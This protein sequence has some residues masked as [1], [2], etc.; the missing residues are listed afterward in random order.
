MNNLQDGERF[1]VVENIHINKEIYHP[2]SRYDDVEDGQYPKIGAKGT[3]KSTYSGLRGNEEGYNQEYIVKWDIQN[4]TR[5]DLVRDWMIKRISPRVGDMAQQISH[6]GENEEPLCYINE[7]TKKDDNKTLIRH[8]HIDNS[9]SSFLDVY[10]YNVENSF[11]IVEHLIKPGDKIQ[12]R[13]HNSI[14]IVTAVKGQKIYALWDKE[15]YISLYLNYEDIELLRK[16]EE[17]GI[18]TR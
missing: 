15:K 14:G 16:G 9:G 2:Y 18:K 5:G 8:T 3:I 6:I 4:E 12:S 1:I 7:I 10:W 17:N 11:I 13:L